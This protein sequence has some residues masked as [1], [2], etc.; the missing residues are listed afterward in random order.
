MQVK[1]FGA[2]CSLKPRDVRS[3]TDVNGIDS[4]GSGEPDPANGE[5]DLPESGIMGEV[6]H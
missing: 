5:L 2:V 4:V 6:W 3:L 1:H